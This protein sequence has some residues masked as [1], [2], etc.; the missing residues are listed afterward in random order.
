MAGT[1]LHGF[2][3]QP[4]AQQAILRWAG[5]VEAEGLDYAAL[6]ERDLERLADLVEAHMDTEKLRLLCGL[7]YA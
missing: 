6:R 1:Y 2:F 7:S 5:L 3:E 4:A